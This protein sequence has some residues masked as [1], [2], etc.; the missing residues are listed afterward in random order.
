MVLPARAFSPPGNKSNF[1]VGD[2]S[3]N[4]STSNMNVF[5]RVRPPNQ[6]ELDGNFR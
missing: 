5:V 3:S 6:K 2:A 4:G 1:S